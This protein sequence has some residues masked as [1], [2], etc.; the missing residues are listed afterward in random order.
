MEDTKRGNTF[1]EFFNPSLEET[2]ANLAGWPS[3]THDRSG[4]QKPM[5]MMV[6][7]KFLK[8]NCKHAHVKPTSLESANVSAISARLAE[9]YRG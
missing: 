5:C 1:G 4:A 7:G 6:T 9:I 2:R 8:E 3:T